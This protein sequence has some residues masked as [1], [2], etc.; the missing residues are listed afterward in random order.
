SK[1]FP[2][3]FYQQGVMSHNVRNGTPMRVV[4]DISDLGDWNLGYQI[5]VSIPVGH[6]KIRYFNQ[7]NGGT[8]LSSPIFTGFEA[9]V[10]QARAGVLQVLRVQAEVTRARR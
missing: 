2:E 7:M 3:P 8:S 1:T 10:L 9:D 6:H 4:P 5:G